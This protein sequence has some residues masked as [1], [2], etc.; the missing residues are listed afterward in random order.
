VIDGRIVTGARGEPPEL[1]AIVLDCAGPVNY[2]GL[3]GTLEAYASV[4]GLNDAYGSRDLSAEEIFRRAGEGDAEAGRALD[5]T[6]GRLAQ[7]CGML[8]NALNLEACILGGGVSNAGEAL[9]ARVERHLPRFTWPML[10][11]N[12]QVRLAEHRNDAG[13]LGAAAFAAGWSGAEGGA[14]L[15]AASAPSQPES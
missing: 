5:A 8:V 4:P 14:A 11:N 9:R 1:G 2:S 7:A 13:I 6:C 3:P 10:L 15:A 12:C